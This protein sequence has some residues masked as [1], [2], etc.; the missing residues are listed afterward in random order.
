MARKR[1]K[2]TQELWL[3]LLF[4][5]IC[6]I[7]KV[8]F[9]YDILAI[10]F[11]ENTVQNEVTNQSNVEIISAIDAKNKQVDS[12]LKVYFLDVG[13]A[14]S[15]LIQNNGKNMLIDAGNNNDGKLLV[16]YFNSLDIEKFD[17]IVGTH[18]H[19]DHIGGL[20]DVINNFNIG[21]IYMP[22][23]STNTSTFEDVLD[24]ID[25][26]NL[27]VTTPRIGD[28]FEMENCD[29]TVM[30]IEKNEEDL[31]Q[32]SIVLKMNFG[33]KSFLF[34]GDATSENEKNML[35]LNISADVLKVGHHGS[36]YSTSKKF[37]EKVNPKYAIISVG[38]DNKYGH[39]TKSILKGLNAK[40]IE[41]HRT[42]QEGTI[43]I[44]SDGENLEIQNIKTNTNGG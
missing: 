36:N 18:P 16:D 25:S 4:I 6:I 26:K 41:I 21:T 27:K 43:L 40:N 19:E 31:N 7:A 13:Q 33:D 12:N 20:D 24:A 23:V 5:I 34:T 38:K 37:L 10:D 22:N 9:D 8:I 3:T 11:E 42:D 28:T 39:P 32:S 44:A 14:D 2:K 30:S 29:F 17:Y 15:I 1:R 35:D